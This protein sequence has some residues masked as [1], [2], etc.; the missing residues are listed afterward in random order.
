MTAYA[1][2]LRLANRFDKTPKTCDLLA[3]FR[4]VSSKFCNVFSSELLKSAAVKLQ[5]VS[6]AMT[7]VQWSIQGQ[8]AMV[9][10]RSVNGT[11]S[12]AGKHHHPST[13]KN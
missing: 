4:D 1:I 12:P 10:N 13:T 8:M 9:P 2:C 3:R 7:S 11:W 5:R 6:N